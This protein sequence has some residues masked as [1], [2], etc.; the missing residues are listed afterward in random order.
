MRYGPL[1][2]SAAVLV[3]LA[4]CKGSDSAMNADLAKD[5]ASAKSNDALALAPRAGVQTVV[6]AQE[7]SPQ[8]RAHLAASSRSSHAV[9]HHAPHR[10]HVARAPAPPEVASVSPA[11]SVPTPSPE[12][13][14]RPQPVDVSYPSTDRGVGRGDGDGGNSGMGG[15]GGIIGAIGGV[16]LR[17]GTVDGDHCDPRSH[18]GGGILINRRGPILRGTF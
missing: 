2:A 8:G 5:L 10:D 12:S 16:V 4:A 14:P 13:S 9:A 7:L 1:F 11:V 3:G 18:R 6:S 15:L 17:G